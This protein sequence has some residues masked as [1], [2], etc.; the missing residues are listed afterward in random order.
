MADQEIAELVGAGRLRVDHVTG[1]VYA[2]RSNTPTKPCGALTAK[3]YLRVCMNVDGRQRHFLA[4]RIVWVSAN[5]PVPV[6]RTIDHVN[7][8]KT[9]NRLDN[10][11]VVSSRENMRRAAANGLY[12]HVGRRDGIRDERG[13]FGKKA[14]GRVL[15]GRT[16]DQYPDRTNPA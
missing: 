16:W 4:H 13:R 10:L 6:G 12:A 14:A 7:T 1:L 15:D 2:P 11:E 3:G 8:I 9:D 5:G